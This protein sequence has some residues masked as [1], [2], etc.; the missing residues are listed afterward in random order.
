MFGCIVNNLYIERLQLFG[1]RIAHAHDIIAAV[2]RSPLAAFRI[3]IIRILLKRL[4]GMRVIDQHA[5]L[6]RF[7]LVLIFFSNIFNLHANALRLIRHIRTLPLRCNR[8]GARLKRKLRRQKFLRIMFQYLCHPAEQRLVRSDRQ[9]EVAGSPICAMAADVFS[10]SSL[11][12]F[13]IDTAPTM[14]A[15]ITS[16]ARIA[17]VM[18]CES[19]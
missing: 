13:E 8:H 6:V 4:V 10:A 12:L 2:L 5:G 16:S 9:P 11:L 17:A 14:I 15:A 19:L 18:S 3:R 7:F 1:Q